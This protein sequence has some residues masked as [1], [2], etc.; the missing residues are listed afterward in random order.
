MMKRALW[1]LLLMLCSYRELRVALQYVRRKLRGF[2]LL[3][4]RRA[5]PG[6]IE[7]RPA[8]VSLRSLDRTRN[9]HELRLET[10]DRGVNH[11]V[12]MSARIDEGEVRRQFG[13][14]ELACFVHI[15]RLRVLDTTADAMAE[16]HI[17]SRLRLAV[18]LG[19]SQE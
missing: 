6:T 3:P 7:D 12:P 10:V 19:L 9:A 11:R 17:E 14:A 2:A 8:I 16:K 1:T 15:T 13:V 4:K 5:E 18:R